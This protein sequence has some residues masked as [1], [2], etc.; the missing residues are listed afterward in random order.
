MSRVTEHLADFTAYQR[1]L[2]QAKRR[3]VAIQHLAPRATG[4]RHPAYRHLLAPSQG[5]GDYA[6]S[7]LAHIRGRPPRQPSAGSTTRSR[8]CCRA[9]SKRS[10]EPRAACC[11]AKWCLPRRSSSCFFEAPTELIA[12][13]RRDTYH[14][15]KIFLTGGACSLILDRAIPKA[16]PADSA[17]TVS[18][19]RRQGTLFGRGKRPLTGGLLRPTISLRLRLC[20]YATSAFPKKRGLAVL[21]TVESS[22]LSLIVLVS[23]HAKQSTNTS[24][25]V[26]LVPTWPSCF[27]TRC[28]K[29]GAECG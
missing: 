28:R 23:L 15:H 1:H 12:K 20:R 14:G 3:A 13:D 2:K 4:P 24:H 17:W 27:P 19:P 29:V 16:N 21:D 10:P 8:R 18:M 22:S 11:T 26:Y 6:S 7:A 9:S 5:T 25:N